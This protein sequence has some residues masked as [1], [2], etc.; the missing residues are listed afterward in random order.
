[1]A[2]YREDSVDRVRDAIDMVALVGAKTDL[3]RAGQARYEG[4]CPFHDERTPSFGI[5]PVKK[6]FHCFGCGAGGDAI[7]FVRETEGVDFKGAI[8]LLADRFGVELEVAEEDP[9]EAARRAQRDRLL[10]LL[11]RTAA[12]YERVLWDSPE[13]SA[14]RSYLL[15]RGLS[16]ESLRAFRVGYS[17]SAWDRVMMASRRA[18]FS[19]AEL[20]ETGLVTRNREGRIYDRFRGRIM[21]PLWDSRGRVIGFGGRAMGE[22]RG[23]KYINTPESRLFHKGNELYAAHLA[24]PAAA[25]AREVVVV[26]GYTDVIA[27]AQAG[28]ENVVASMGT[29][30]TDAQV[31]RLAMLAPLAR[32]A[33]DAD[34]AGQ[35]AMRRAARV[36]G[37][38]LDLRVVSLPAG[39]DPADLAVR[40]PERMRSLLADAQDVQLFL[41]KRALAGADLSSARGKDAVL[42]ELG[43]LYAEIRSK[44]L[45]IEVLG[46]VSSSV[47]LSPEQTEALLREYRNAAPP[48][49]GPR[50]PRDAGPSGSPGDDAAPA[51]ARRMSRAL[52]AV[53]EIERTFLSQ[54]LAL[55][56]P[57]REALAKIDFEEHLTTPLH[58]RL[59]EHIRQHPDSPLDAA[60]PEDDELRAAIADL[61]ARRSRDPAS[62]ATL[63][64][65]RLQLELRRLTRRLNAARRAGEPG[66]TEIA[67]QREQV[68]AQLDT[69]IERVMSTS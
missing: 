6:L 26:E 29:A 30:L 5:D 36:A 8:E 32:L 9:A 68:Q 20:V 51:P 45:A 54:C 19:E 38:E 41:V 24:R 52:S 15:G 49:R 63:D 56:G 58:R 47:D 50:R 4:L 31:K 37:D 25:K 60:P 53:D 42:R 59:A 13:A 33:M 1:M 65:Q 3:R 48:D 23:A 11:E 10:S 64:A 18:G 62:L 2:R 46:L 17:P 66:V 14:A 35:E 55:P 39:E 44:V 34:T 27:L 28:F 61:E 43:P 69:A 67:A 22:A 40:D 16:E 12:Y 7:D 57:G 21:F